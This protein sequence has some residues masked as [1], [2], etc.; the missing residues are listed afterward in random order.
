MFGA[1]G[2]EQPSGFQQGCFKN[3]KL[4]RRPRIQ[5]TER[6][7]GEERP[8]H[9][10]RSAPIVSGR[11]GR[12]HPKGTLLGFR[13]DPTAAWSPRG[14]QPW[15]GDPPGAGPWP[16]SL[17]IPGR[18]R[19]STD[20]STRLNPRARGGTLPA[21]VGDEGTAVTRCPHSFAEPGAESAVLFHAGFGLHLLQR[22]RQLCPELHLLHLDLLPAG[23][24]WQS[25]G[26]SGG[27]VPRTLSV[28]AQ[29]GGDPIPHCLLPLSLPQ[30]QPEM[31]YPAPEALEM[32]PAQPGL[33]SGSGSSPRGPQ[34]HTGAGGSGL[35]GG[36]WE[37][38][39]PPGS[40]PSSPE[41]NKFPSSRV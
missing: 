34:P 18:S 35:L 6:L 15:L 2:R 9:R 8:R 24:R 41:L 16:R 13:D 30:S 19:L 32:Q 11:G 21:G 31:E 20:L 1:S 17:S 23:G 3:N 36:D 27:G 40:H 25:R 26:V 22:H 5:G 14:P 33:G 7:P 4:P 10:G 29:G 39:S 37:P 28:G 38:P 12:S